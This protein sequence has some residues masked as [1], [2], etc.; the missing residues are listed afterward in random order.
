VYSKGPNGYSPPGDSGGHVKYAGLKKIGAGNVAVS[1]PYS[2]DVLLT[3]NAGTQKTHNSAYIDIAVSERGYLSGADG[4][5]WP[6][7]SSGRRIT[8]FPY[9]LRIDARDTR[10]F[11]ADY[12][13]LLKK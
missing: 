5:I 13:N 11:A 12:K 9:S 4:D 7:P 8:D 6:E 1:A 10:R 2:G 3:F